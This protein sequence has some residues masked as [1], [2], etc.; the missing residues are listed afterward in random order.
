MA[1]TWEKWLELYQKSPGIGGGAQD[2]THLVTPENYNDI[3]FWRGNPGITICLSRPDNSASAPFEYGLIL[4]TV[5]NM[6]VSQIFY[7]QA[8]GSIMRR[9]G[10]GNGWNGQANVLGQNAWVPIATNEYVEELTLKNYQHKATVYND[11]RPFTTSTALG[12][13]IGSLPDGSM[14]IYIITA[15]N[16]VATNSLNKIP[17][18]LPCLLRIIKTSG[19]YDMEVSQAGGTF[20]HTFF[21]GLKLGSSEIRWYRYS[22]TQV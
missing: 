22:G 19:R 17:E 1:L 12:D 2:I 11:Y 6:E 3:N 4:T 13:I 14:L 21:K 15:D 9:S 16:P 5:V 8:V 20:G 18:I 7:T 10:D